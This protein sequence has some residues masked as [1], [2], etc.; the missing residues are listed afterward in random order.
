MDGQKVVQVFNHEEAATADFRGLNDR[1]FEDSSKANAY[2][3]VLAPIIGNLGN[4]LYVLVAVVGGL[5]IQLEATNIGLSG[6]GTMTMGIIVSYL[7]QSCP[8]C[9][10][11]QVLFLFFFCFFQLP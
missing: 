3:N 7:G 2:G 8:S 5:L 10:I 11:L 1:L 9:Q 6:M 4:L